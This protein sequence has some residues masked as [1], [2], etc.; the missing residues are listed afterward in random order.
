LYNFQ[1][2]NSW[3]DCPQRLHG[4]T[5]SFA[6]GNLQCRNDMYKHLAWEDAEFRCLHACFMRRSS[7]EPEAASGGVARQNVTEEQHMGLKRNVLRWWLA[8]SGKQLQSRWKREKYQRGPLVEKD[9]TPFF[10]LQ[11]EPSMGDHVTAKGR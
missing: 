7:L 3:T 1:M 11:I 2:L 9:A 5:A 6:R 10:E 8:R 4:G